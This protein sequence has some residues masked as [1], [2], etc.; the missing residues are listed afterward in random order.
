MSPSHPH[1]GTLELVGWVRQT[2]V[3]CA[4]ASGQLGQYIPD[5]QLR[6]LMAEIAGADTTPRAV[7]AGVSLD[8]SDRC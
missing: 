2:R 6:D 5:Q 8:L 1:A 4:N 7:L 3:L